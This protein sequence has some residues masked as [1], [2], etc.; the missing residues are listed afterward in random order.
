MSHLYDFL[1]A[2]LLRFYE[3][4]GAEA[5][6]IPMSTQSDVKISFFIC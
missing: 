2:G 1:F 4:S 5:K 3:L 6:L